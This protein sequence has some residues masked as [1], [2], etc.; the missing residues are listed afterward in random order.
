V[1]G[2][3]LGKARS[4][5]SMVRLS[6]TVFAM[7]FA[8]VALLVA[9]DGRPGLVLLGLVLLAVFSART[10]AMAY[11][12]IVDR[13]VD[14]RNPRTAGREIPSGA[15]SL[16]LAIGLAVVSSV[17]FVAACWPLGTWCRI[18]SLPLLVWLC[19]YSHVKRFSMLCHVWLGAALGL[20]PVAAWVAAQSSAGAVDP[21][22]LVA[23]GVLALAVMTWVAGFDI[24]YACQDADFDREQGLFSIPSRLGV[25]RAMWLSRVSHGAA[26]VGFVL[27]GW[28]AGLGWC[29]GA[30]CLLGAGLL[31]V[32]HRNLAVERIGAALF[33]QN[34]LLSLCMLLGCGLDLYLFGIDAPVGG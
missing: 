19:A 34:G 17:V 4:L 1:K 8:L 26:A 11:N 25:R 18:G 20:A 30:S 15:V 23:P 21:S 22:T 6:H 33:T 3:L 27:F 9:T 10:A 2:V 31:L 13:D 28:L 5:A 32:Q 12:R 16:P 7:P 14:A 29:Y 24:L